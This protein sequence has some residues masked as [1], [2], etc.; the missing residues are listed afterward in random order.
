MDPSALRALPAVN[1]ILAHIKIKE[2]EKLHGRN[3]IVFVVRRVLKDYRAQILSDNNKSP[4]MDCDE[5]VQFCIREIKN[6]AQP[7][8]RKVINATGI[9][10]HTNL[11]RA[12]LGKYVLDDIKKEVEN[13]SNLEF[14]LGGGCRGQRN[15]HTRDLITFLT[16]AEDAVVVNNN[17]AAIILVLNTLAKGKE[18]LVS[19]G[20]LIEI[21]GAFRIPQIMEA[22][23]VRMIEVGTTNRTRL[24][25]YEEAIGPNT[26]L[27]FKAHRSNFEMKGFVEEVSVA[28][29]SKLARDKGILMVY[30]IGSGLLRK[31]E[32]L[33]LQNEPDVQTAINMNPDIVTF[34]CDKLLGGPQAGVIAGKSNL[35]GLCGKAP[36]MRALRVGKLTIAALSSVCRNYLTDDALKEKT[37]AFAL[38]SQSLETIEKRA[39]FLCDQINK[40]NMDSDVEAVVVDSRAQVGG[41]ALP[42]LYIPSKAVALNTTMGSSKKKEAFAE[43]LYAR[44][45]KEALPIVSILREGRLLFD[46]CTLFDN[47]IKSIAQSVTICLK[48]RKIK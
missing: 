36:L 35:V 7:S 40:L 8:L 33:P 26:A 48:E 15:L 1:K 42:E 18:I 12:P 24:S 22:S 19:R 47:D 41:G 25:D 2:I 9:I 43:A 37:P 44:L 32:N 20:E 45:M 30:D 31:P 16:G 5:I 17:A 27:I 4:I 38:M 34:S 46:V 23:G 39:S 3:L 21:G 28:D 10:L 29:L 14:F 13:Y 11:G 6:I